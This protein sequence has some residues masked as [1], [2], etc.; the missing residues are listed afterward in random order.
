MITASPIGKV[1]LQLPCILVHLREQG[2]RRLGYRH[3]VGCAG[4]I[5]CHWSVTKMAPL[6]P[7]HIHDLCTVTL[8][9]SHPE[10]MSLFPTLD[11]GW[12]LDHSRKESM[13]ALSE[14]PASPRTPLLSQKVLPS[15]QETRP[16][17]DRVTQHTP[18]PLII[19]RCITN[20]PKLCGLKQQFVTP[21]SILQVSRMFADR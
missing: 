19:Y 12:P 15:H 18:S 1:T 8:Q 9:T 13:P 7:P 5:S 3:P 10:L 6:S 21:F 2:P 17:G 11:S 20:H 16:L 4:H 14:D